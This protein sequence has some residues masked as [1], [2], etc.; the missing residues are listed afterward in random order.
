[1]TGE[2]TNKRLASYIIRRTVWHKSVEEVM[3]KVIQI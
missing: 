2:T 3:D 1:M